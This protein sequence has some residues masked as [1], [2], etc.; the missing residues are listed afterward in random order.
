[1]NAI[2]LE[3][4]FT[5]KVAKISGIA[6][7]VLIIGAYAVWRSLNYARGP[8]IDIISPIQGASITT[9]TTDIIG[10]IQRAVNVSLNGR[11]INIDEQGNFKETLIVFRGT[12][13]LTFEAKDQFERS[14]K[15]ELRLYGI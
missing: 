6:L 14:I 7:I 15:S 11:A 12:N 2:Y 8:E 1:M 9:S 3:R 5:S 4:R 10:K 13:I